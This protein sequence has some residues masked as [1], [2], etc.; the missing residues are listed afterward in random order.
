MNR[1]AVLCDA[2]LA[3]LI[4]KNVSEKWEG[5][6]INTAR[7]VAGQLIRHGRVPRSYL[8]LGG[9][10]VPVARRVVRFHSLTAESGVQILSVEPDSPSARAHLQI[11]DII[12]V[13]SQPQNYAANIP[14][15]AGALCWVLYTVGASYFPTWS[16]YKYTAITTAL[17]L[18]SIYAIDAVLIAIG[19]IP[20]P[21][22]TKLAAVTPHLLYMAL[23]AGFIGVLSWNLGNKI[24]TPLNG[25]LFMDVV[26]VTAFTISA[27]TGVLG[28]ARWGLIQHDV[29]P[30]GIGGL[31]TLLNLEANEKAQEAAVW[32]TE[33]DGRQLVT[34]GW[35]MG[36]G[37]I[38]SGDHALESFL[39]DA[40]NR[41]VTLPDGTKVEFSIEDNLGWQ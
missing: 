10:N 14:L 22:F 18:T 39:P 29:E 3:E 4:R 6:E 20:A 16:P 12:G 26:P 8:G 23:V 37:S 28:K 32:I 15:I 38:Y 40:A 5:H 21:T 31:N 33:K 1:L 19:V 17:G 41:T 34:F 7:F 25:V 27:L 11:G 24:I 13:I 35:G 2:R 9:Q 30:N 36:F